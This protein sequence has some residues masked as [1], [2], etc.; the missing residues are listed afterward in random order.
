MQLQILFTI[1]S[2]LLLME[3]IDYDLLFRRFV[4]LATV[5]RPSGAAPTFSRFSSP[6]TAAGI[7]SIESSSVQKY[8]AMS[9][10]VG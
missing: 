3:H 4:G 6:K 2:E 10:C 8:L 5:T 9:N 1:R 7:C